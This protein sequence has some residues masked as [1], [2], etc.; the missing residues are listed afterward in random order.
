M[1]KITLKEFYKSVDLLSD[2]EDNE[3]SK[4]AEI[5]LVK[6]LKRDAQHD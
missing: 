6:K 2:L 1:D 3:F 4:L 5:T